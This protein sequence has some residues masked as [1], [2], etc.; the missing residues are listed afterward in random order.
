MYY[1]SKFLYP[2][3]HQEDEQMKNGIQK[4]NANMYPHFQIVTDQI[5]ESIQELLSDTYILDKETCNDYIFIY[6]YKF[7]LTHIVLIYIYSY[8][9]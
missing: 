1:I 3:P 5:V 2:L 6:T 7:S 9:H 4:R 8:I